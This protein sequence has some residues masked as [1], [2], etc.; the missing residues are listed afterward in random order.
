M[1][2]LN[3]SICFSKSCFFAC[4][5]SPLS[6]SF[7]SNVWLES[8]SLVRFSSFCNFWRCRIAL[9][10]PSLLS[11]PPPPVSLPLRLIFTATASA[12]AA[13]EESNPAPPQFAFFALPLPR[14]PTP[15]PS[16]LLLFD[17]PFF[18]PPPNL[19]LVL[20]QHP[21]QPG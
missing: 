17:E 11:C 15:P 21:N 8:N 5:R 20:S 16:P 13:N 6:G 12:L 2:S 7:D 19:S 3:C 10:F 1:D 4:A 9:D 18:F 14:M